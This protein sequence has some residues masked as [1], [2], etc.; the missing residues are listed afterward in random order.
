MMKTKK[1]YSKS[2]FLFLVLFGVGINIKTFTVLGMENEV[3]TNGE[4]I[5]YEESSG[6]TS[7]T[8]T[9]ESSVTKPTESSTA[10]TTKPIGRFPSTGELIGKSLGISGILMLIFI[11]LF[12]LL[13]R[14]K[15][16]DDKEE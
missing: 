8:S 16:A 13:K 12:Y 5:F 2:I 10:G 14:K 4:I 15:P 6:S 11:L 3:Q 1:N 9:K 7:S